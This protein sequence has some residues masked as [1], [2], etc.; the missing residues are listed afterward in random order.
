MAGRR[1]YGRVLWPHSLSVGAA[2]LVGF[3]S[4]IR[5]RAGMFLGAVTA[6]SKPGGQAAAALL[7][8]RLRAVT[9]LPRS[10]AR[11]APPFPSLCS[12]ACA[13]CALWGLEP[14]EGATRHCLS[15]R[16]M[17]VL[18]LPTLQTDSSH[19]VSHKVHVA[20][21]FCAGIIFFP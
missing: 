1:G 5:L 8:F 4:F 16:E 19:T 3:L 2:G 18:C 7:Q 21:H 9:P 11:A 20:R 17:D 10:R 15:I 12:E 6:P 13:R 14:A